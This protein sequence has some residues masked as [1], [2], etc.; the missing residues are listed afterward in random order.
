MQWTEREEAEAELV[1]E[2]F[3]SGR[4]LSCSGIV[5]PSLIEADD[6][7]ESEPGQAAASAPAQPSQARSASR[8]VPPTEPLDAGNEGPR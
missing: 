8:E 1:R 7:A 6:Q 2:V 4:F 5:S 3:G